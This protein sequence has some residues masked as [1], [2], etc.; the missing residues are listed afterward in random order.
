[1]WHYTF[2]KNNLR[3]THKRQGIFAR[4][5]GGGGKRFF[6]YGKDSPTK[7][8]IL[9]KR[10]LLKEAAAKGLLK[11]GYR[12][13][14][15]LNLLPVKC[16]RAGLDRCYVAYLSKCDLSHVTKA[17]WFISLRRR[18]LY[19]WTVGSRGY[20]PSNLIPHFTLNY[21]CG[22][23]NLSLLLNFFQ[24]RHGGKFAAFRKFKKITNQISIQKLRLA[25][26]ARSFNG[27]VA[28][29]NGYQIL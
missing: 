29:S 24:S 27:W 13:I 21:E 6:E 15:G 3:L 22:V 8:A 10:W 20:I 18:R 23:D 26:M 2:S 9:A 11:N 1:M 12:V 17:V 7:T 4:C 14:H 5:Q 25:R 28:I 16:Q 19:R